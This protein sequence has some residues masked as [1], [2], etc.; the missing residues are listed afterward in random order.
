M[1]YGLQCI[2]V[3]S[4]G[5]SVARDCGRVV[6]DRLEESDTAS[7]NDTIVDTEIEGSDIDVEIDT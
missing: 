7:E 2:D 6:E 4:P 5:Q 1:W 3:V